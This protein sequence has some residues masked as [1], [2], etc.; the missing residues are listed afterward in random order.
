[1]STTENHKDQD[2]V[3]SRKVL[4]TLTVANEYCLYLEKSEERTREE[5]I[6]FLQKVLPLIYLKLALLP[7]VEVTD[8]DAVQH[9]VTE[10][11]WEGMFNLLRSKFGNLDEFFFIDHHEKSHFD[12]VKASI[13]ENLT[14]I[15]QDLSDFV[16]LYQNPLRTFRENAV[17]EL[18]EF[19][20]LRTGIRIVNTLTILHYLSGMPSESDFS[21]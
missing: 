11:Q 17:R 5:M 18:K 12:P 16:M 8:E 19:F 10:E 6:L 7:E 3:A 20:Y 13:S 9:Y 21:E 14:D 2:P 4:E 1:M 15:Y